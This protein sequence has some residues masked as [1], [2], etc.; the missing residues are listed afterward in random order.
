MS[1]RRW[2]PSCSER[3]SGSGANV[4][5]DITLDTGALIAIE[6]RKQR[7]IQFVERAREQRLRLTAPAPVIAEWWRGRTDEREDILLAIIVEPP[8]LAIARVAGEAIARVR[9]AT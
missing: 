4:L 9:G 5:P 2:M 6:R 7:A 8:S 1:A 3:Q